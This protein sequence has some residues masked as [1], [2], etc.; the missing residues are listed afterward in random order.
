MPRRL[1]WL[2]S[3]WRPIVAFDL[4]VRLLLIAVFA[5]LSAWF[6]RAIL[7]WSGDVVVSNFDLV[8]FFLSPP[9]LSLIFVS[10]TVGSAVALFEFG[11]LILFVQ[12]ARQGVEVSVVR[13]LALLSRRAG[14]LLAL[15]LRQFLGVGAVA[16]VFLAVVELTRRTL[17]GG[18]DIYYYLQVRP[19]AWW[20]AVAIVILVAVV[21]VGLVVALLLGW[22]VALPQLLLENAGAREAMAAS[23]LQIS[24]RGIWRVVGRVMRWAG[25]MV[26]VFV[27]LGLSRQILEWAA[28]RV[29]GE[30]VPWVLTVAG[31]MLAIDFVLGL[32]AGFVGSLTL[33][34]LVANLY[35]EMRG[36][37]ALPP[38]LLSTRPGD[39]RRRV[40]LIVVGLAVAAGLATLAWITVSE[41]VDEIRLD[42]D[43]LVTAHRGSAKAAPENTISALKQ[44][45]VDG[46][47]YAEIDVQETAD[48]V[49]VLFHDT[50]LRRMAG[51]DR[52]I[53]NIT[54]N[55]FRQLDIGS[56]F[57]EEFAGERIATLEEAINTVRGR[58]KLNIELKFNGHEQRLE[59][60]VARLVRE[61]GFRDECVVTSLDY[62]GIQR[63]GQ[64][65]PGLRRG[66]I[67]TAGV[68]DATRLDL[69]LLAVNANRVSR[70][71]VA[72]AHR[73][74]K[75]VHVWTVND[76]DQM[77]TMIHMGVDNILTSTPDVLVDLLEARAGMTHEQRVLLLVADFLE[78][79]L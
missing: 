3:S 71:M 13:V 73:A 26:M 15:G 18:G 68:G 7:S 56:W 41:I 54:F 14:G 78:G 69:D 32:I 58:M 51:V 9:G 42:D 12:S 44:A 59:S 33:A 45:M 34:V 40:R 76:P 29:A 17:L 74:G 77:L 21:A 23:R 75:E 62:G 19:L 22:C 43:V 38:P 67:L 57:S 49:L 79:R 16:T 6:L 72:R 8:S 70:R 24:E 48:G 10:A 35:T 31:F 20:G 63:I 30:R 66:L 36:Q 52:P 61:A 64:H 27:L 55:E 2:L 39:G 50:D 28:L 53:W 11:G 60:E 37:L 5:P 46:A 65:D 47:D 1:G 25:G 4:S